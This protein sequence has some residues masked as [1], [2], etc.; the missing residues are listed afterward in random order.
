MSDLAD[1]TVLITGASTGIGAAV[2]RAFGKLGARVAVH[3]HSSKAAAAHVAADIVGDGGD[4]YLVYADARESSDMR[5]AVESTIGH[6]GKLDILINNV[7]ALVRR[8]PIDQ[9][10]DKLFNEIIDLN[11]RSALIAILPLISSRST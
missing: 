10:D 7:G 8:M 9:F 3:Y 2:A 11:V 1:K 4:A 6:F 5:R